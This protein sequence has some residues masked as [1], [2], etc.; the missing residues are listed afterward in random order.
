MQRDLRYML[1]RVAIGLCIGVGMF[2]F[3]S[4]HAQLTP[5]GVEYYQRLGFSAADVAWVN[6]RAGGY[7]PGPIP[8]QLFATGVN[9]TAAGPI[10]NG[11][12]TF[13]PFQGKVP[14]VAIP[15]A[16][17]L[18][19]GVLAPAVRLLARAQ[20]LVMIG[21]GAYS[22][23][24]DQR[25][26]YDQTEKDWIKYGPGDPIGNCSNGYQGGS[27]GTGVKLEVCRATLLQI[28]K[29]TYPSQA[30]TMTGTELVPNGGNTLVKIVTSPPNNSNINPNAGTFF[31]T[32]DTQV[33]LRP[34]TDADMDDAWR[35]G[36]GTAAQEASVVQPII[37]AKTPI[38]LRGAPTTTTLPGP[39][40]GPTTV[41][42]SSVRNADGT[43]TNTRTETSQSLQTSTQGTTFDTQLL[44]TRI[45]E[46]TI[47]T[48]TNTNTIIR[49]T[50]TTPEFERPDAPTPDAPEPE[51]EI[52]FNDSSLPEQPE[53]YVQKYPGGI[54]G[55]WDAKRTQ[56]TNSAFIQGV[57]S[58]FPTI[59]G[60]GSCPVW[61]M[62]LNFGQYANFGTRDI[63]V[64]C[65]LW[66]IVGL[67]FLI[68]ATFA[69]RRILFGG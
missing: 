54:K 40:A 69:A 49:D 63:S 28:A 30:S 60:G 4:A 33:K 23:Y 7:T 6:G 38:N 29:N 8:S 42:T 18:T 46:R 11:N 22:L 62:P 27:A 25:V 68:T 41:T 36:N 61:Q 66:H 13:I 53:L 34:A 58:M 55:V 47:V 10:I 52:T 5:T 51:P 44:L 48:D 24:Q 50:T 67:I 26:L 39:I 21:L 59:A 17:T 9:A 3:R 2:Y 1:V 20:P 32:A 15:E 35:N 16:V 57:R 14:R 65:F 56:L 12:R 45:T 31:K 64:P 19:R 37:D 43:T